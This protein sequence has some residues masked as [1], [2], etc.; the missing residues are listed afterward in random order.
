MHTRFKQRREGILAARSEVLALSAERLVGE[1]HTFAAL[2]DAPLL[3]ALAVSY[4][5]A[6]D[7]VRRAARTGAA[8]AP[9]LVQFESTGREVVA[10]LMRL[11]A[12]IPPREG[13][14]GKLPVSAAGA[15]P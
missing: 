14:S 2:G 3:A 7:N 6:I 12:T 1:L 11:Q 15:R 5:V 9:V 10:A 13:P 4:Q 8:M